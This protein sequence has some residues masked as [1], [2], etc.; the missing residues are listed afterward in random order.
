[1]THVLCST[2]RISMAAQDLCRRRMRKI[3]G[4]NSVLASTRIALLLATLTV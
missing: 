2:I 1:M 4:E 3:K